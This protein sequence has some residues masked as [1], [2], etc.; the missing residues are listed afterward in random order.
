MNQ[1]Y[2]LNYRK[3]N[4][5][6][7]FPVIEE[8]GVPKYINKP[9]FRYTFNPD[10]S[11]YILSNTSWDSFHSKNQAFL[12]KHKN[13]LPVIELFYPSPEKNSDNHWQ[14]LSGNL[15]LQSVCENRRREHDNKVPYTK[16]M[17]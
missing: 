6:C 13:Y 1:A 14:F 2:G 7:I 3:A 12:Q 5:N 10:R 11:Y 15:Q 4:Q 8:L 9:N 16:D 17:I